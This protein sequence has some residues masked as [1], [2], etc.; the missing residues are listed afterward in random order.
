[1]IFVSYSH[2]D[3]KWRE[4][5]ARISKPL[6]STEGIR[7][8]SDRDLKAGEWEPQIERAMRGAVAAVLL[9][10]DNYVASDYVVR[11]EWP[12][13]LRAQRERNLM[14]FWAY[15]EPCDLKRNPGR[16]IKRFQAMT[17]GELEPMSK[18]TDWK[19]KETMLRGCDMIDEFLK[20]LER[21]LINPKVRGKS[22]P[23]I[24]DKVPLLAKPARRRVEV[25]VYSPNKKWWRQR[26]VNKGETTTQIHVGNEDTKPGTKFKVV[27]MTTE[28]PLTQQVY[29]NLPH[30]TKS[31]E[32]TLV[33][34]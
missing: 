22:F 15:L 4:R 7:F 21:P 30:R 26:S 13:L 32:V 17:L 33:R 3:E 24:A 8:W 14:I 12:Y 29:L 23:R 1:M 27:A 20:K 28:G 5:F 6:S 2:G 9:V 34:K 25:L 10:S 31:E 11:K 19:W 16:A 18:M